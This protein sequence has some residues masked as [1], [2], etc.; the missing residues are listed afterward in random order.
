LVRQFDETGERTI[1][2]LTKPDRIEPGDER[3]WLDMLRNRTEKFK[4]GWFCVKQPGLNELQAHITPEEAMKNESDFFKNTRPWSTAE[5]GLRARFGTEALSKALSQ[6]LFEVIARRFVYPPSIFLSVDILF[7]LP[8]IENE[9][10]RSLKDV[11]TALGAL[12]YKVPKD[13]LIEIHALLSQFHIRI[14]NTVVKGTSSDPTRMIQG[15]NKAY[16]QFV[17]DIGCMTPRFRP[18]S[19]SGSSAHGL[20]PEYP[21]KLQLREVAEDKLQS[22]IVYLDEISTRLEE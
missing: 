10:H 19:R 6:K 2:V 15:A 11:D 14:H 21:D 1:P 22:N 13:P 5:P 3:K 8:E 4:H 17:E 20:F 9:L 12:Q 16:R 7:S 18:W